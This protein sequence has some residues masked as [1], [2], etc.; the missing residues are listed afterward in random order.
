MHFRIALGFAIVA[1]V[2]YSTPV[3]P[4]YLKIDN[5]VPNSVNPTSSSSPVYVLNV[6]GIQIYGPMCPSTG[7]IRL[8]QKSSI[9]HLYAVTYYSFGDGSISC[10]MSSYMTYPHDVLD[11]AAPNVARNSSYCIDA[12]DSSYCATDFLGALFSWKS[13]TGLPCSTFFSLDICFVQLNI[14]HNININSTA[15]LRLISHR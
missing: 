6:A 10:N 11:R 2:V 13:F 3:T 12:E 14:A 4:L 1:R 5:P 7:C 9:S 8:A 15:L